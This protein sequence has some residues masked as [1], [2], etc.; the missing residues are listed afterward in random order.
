MTEP[1]A[2][3]Q[4]VAAFNSTYPTLKE[5]AVATYGAFSNQT[6]VEFLILKHPSKLEYTVLPWSQYR[7]LGSDDG[8]PVWLVLFRGTLSMLREILSAFPPDFFDSLQTGPA[9][10]SPA[11]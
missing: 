11:E 8:R 10:P 9:Q 3:F 5:C 1:A 2:K 4:S 6:Q 7:H